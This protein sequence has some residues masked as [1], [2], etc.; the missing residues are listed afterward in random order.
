MRYHC[1]CSIRLSTSPSCTSLPS[2]SSSSATKAAPDLTRPAADLSRC[3]FAPPS[4]VPDLCGSCTNRAGTLSWLSP[5]SNVM[6]YVPSARTCDTRP[7]YQPSGPFVHPQSM[8][9]P[10]SPWPGGMNARA[11]TESPSW[12]LGWN[13]TGGWTTDLSLVAWMYRMALGMSCRPLSLQSLPRSP[14]MCVTASVHSA[15]G[16]CARRL[17]STWS[18]TGPRRPSGKH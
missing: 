9:S 10:S 2:S 16:T 8:D 12:N 1:G 3:L 5:S 17:W 6:E 18:L 15:L 4:L 14:T 13:G 7:G 11:M